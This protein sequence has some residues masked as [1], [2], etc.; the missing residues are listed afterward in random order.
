M[1]IP[2]PSPKRQCWF[3]TVSLLPSTLNAGGVGFRNV[4]VRYSAL[5]QRG[6]FFRVY[7]SQVFAFEGILSVAH[8]LWLL[9]CSSPIV[10]LHK[11]V[12]SMGVVSCMLNCSLGRSSVVR[13]V[14]YVIQVGDRI[15]LHRT[16]NEPPSSRTSDLEPFEPQAQGFEDKAFENLGCASTHYTHRRR[17]YVNIVYVARRR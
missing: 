17:V 11:W 9:T 10:V 1:H 3:S 4:H 13:R 5:K 7:R 15:G 14:S 8:H 6:L 16:V 2:P 12:S